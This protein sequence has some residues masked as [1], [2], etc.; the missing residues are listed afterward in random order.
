MKLRL[1]V[2]ESL[3]MVSRCSITRNRLLI[4]GSNWSWRSMSWG[5]L[6]LE[7]K[8]K[9]WADSSFPTLKSLKWHDCIRQ[10][11]DILTCYFHSDCCPHLATKWIT[12]LLSTACETL[13]TFRTI[14]A[15]N[16]SQWTAKA[17]PRSQIPSKHTKWTVDVHVSGA[18]SAP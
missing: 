16:A 1:Q 2:L 17:N 5:I 3:G 9:S 6:A 12:M 8:F 13:F 14:T 10:V 4:M 11:C 15:G 7:E 18:Q